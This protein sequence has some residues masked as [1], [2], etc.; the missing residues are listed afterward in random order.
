RENFR[1]EWK[2]LATKTVNPNSTH[3]TDSSRWICSCYSFLLSRFHICKHLIQIY[4]PVEPGFF[5]KVIR[6]EH[7]PLLEIKEENAF[8]DLPEDIRASIKN[9]NSYT[10]EL[11]SSG[12][13]VNN[14]VHEQESVTISSNEY[15][16]DVVN[17]YS[18]DVVND[19]QD[20][21][22]FQTRKKEI[23][24][25]LDET[26]NILEKNVE[27]PN[28]W[29]DSIEK[30]FEPLRKLVEDCK[31]FERQTHIPNTW[32]NRNNNTFWL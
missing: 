16:M 24:N 8:A 3:I 27:N 9:L 10:Y 1:L 5:K 23:F 17:E 31:R 29:L 6:Q 28:K 12:S 32:K 18:M 13:Q 26:K 11:I 14:Q 19:D 2:K 25:L 4:G 7:Y 21:I 30:N 22:L 20:L 15:L